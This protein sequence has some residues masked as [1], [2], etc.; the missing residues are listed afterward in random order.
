MGHKAAAPALVQ[1]LLRFPGNLRAGKQAKHRRSAAG[2]PRACRAMRP[3]GG[4]ALTNL[5]PQFRANPLEH[6]PQAA[7]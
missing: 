2:H 5:R 1:L 3:Q 6:I 7:A 4:N